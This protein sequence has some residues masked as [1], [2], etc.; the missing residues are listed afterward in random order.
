MKS[1]REEITLVKVPVYTMFD[2][3]VY[4][5]FYSC[6]F[7]TKINSFYIVCNEVFSLFLNYCLIVKITNI[8]NFP[9]KQPQRIL[10]NLYRRIYKSLNAL[11]FTSQY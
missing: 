7:A 3:H 10:V 5:L 1:G 6:V 8:H 11:Q 2:I 4:P 9:M